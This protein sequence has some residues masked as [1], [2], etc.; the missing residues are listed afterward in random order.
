MNMIMVRVIYMLLFRLP[1]TAIF[2]GISAMT[3]QQLRSINGFSNRY[4][5]WGGEDDDLADRCAIFCG[6]SV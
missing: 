2:G 3:V 4:W 6:S 5:G 1:Y